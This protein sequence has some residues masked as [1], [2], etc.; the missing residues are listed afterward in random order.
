M[1]IIKAPNAE[2]APEAPEAPVA[3]AAPDAPK[4]LKSD[5]KLED[6]THTKSA[7]TKPEKKTHQKVLLG[8]VY[9]FEDARTRS[10]SKSGGKA[11]VS[12]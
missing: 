6:G 12:L 3:P 2:T 9:Q 8:D 7:K 10:I 5:M 4:N 11:R 1:V